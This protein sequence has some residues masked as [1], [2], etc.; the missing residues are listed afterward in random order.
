M[1]N[2]S[3]AFK[4]AMRA[5]VKEVDSYIKL[6]D[7]TTITA[8]GDLVSTRVETENHLGQVAMRLLTLQLMGDHSNLKGQTVTLYVGVKVSGSFE[9]LDYGQFLVQD[10]TQNKGTGMTE[11]KAYDKVLFLN[12]KY[13]A[14]KFTYPASVYQVA[15][16][17]CQEA[18][19]A[20]G[21]TVWPNSTLIIPTDRYEGI[22]NIQYRDVIEDI[23]AAS[24]TIAMISNNTLI[25]K[26]PPEATET[27]TEANLM[28]YE[29]GDKYGPINAVVLARSPQEDNVA[30][31]NEES[32]E[33]NGL[34]EWR[35]DNIQLIDDQRET[36]IVELYNG[37]NGL[38]Y[39][40]FSAKTEGHG[41][42]ELGDTLNISVEGETKK[43]LISYISLFID[44]SIEENVKGVSQQSSGTN[45]NRAG[46]IS[47]RI[48]RTEIIVDKQNAKIE[49]VVEQVNGQEDKITSITQTSELIDITVSEINEGL[50]KQQTSFVVEND[51][52]YIKQGRE[53]YYSKFTDEGMQVYSN[54]EKI[55]EATASTFK[56]PSFTTT[57][58]TM[59]EEE[60]GKVLNFFRGEL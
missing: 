56:A 42:Y 33:A 28:T 1:Y 40:P 27:L 43:V 53:G 15:A 7:N 23:A 50:Q 30:L 36:A 60:D 16:T 35:A 3:A 44:G 25:F 12:Q 41:W 31:R 10:A 29:V 32:I 2:A 20:L 38:T 59:R 48:S 11:A 26:T 51:G 19:I 17:A 21:S 4:N 39:Y 45:Y 49:S 13:E 55:A 18:G 57:N 54:G 34:T 37:L 47:N 5:E 6:A 46:S 58:W 52:S 24:G 22:E 8:A 14:S 9:Y